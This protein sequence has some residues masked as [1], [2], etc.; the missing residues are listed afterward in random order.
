[1]AARKYTPEEAAARHREASRKRIAA[2]RK[3]HPEE[4]R[5]KKRIY[6]ANQ[7]PEKK[8]E[9][10]EKARLAMAAWR[11]AHPQ[12]SRARVKAYK[13]ANREKHRE[14]HRKSKAKWKAALDPDRREA[15]KGK[16]NESRR[17]SYRTNPE[18]HREAHRNYHEAHPGLATKWRREWAAA[19]RER[20]RENQKR[21]RQMNK[22]AYLV[23]VAGRRAR[24]KGL[25]FDGLAE[26]KA[27]RPAKCLCCGKELDYSCENRR[28]A[29]SLDRVDNLK[30][31]VA[32]NVRIICWECNWVKSDASLDRLK[33]IIA[34]IE[35][36]LSQ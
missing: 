13:L 10:K 33:Q 35:A 9:E 15:M 2:W 27:S 12:E 26:I 24:A 5:K 25:E 23:S 29:P 19:H 14:S 36:N 22:M 4:A 34:Y 1:M 30:G 3:E 31:Y 21:Q 28:C 17:E 16:R 32:A 11:K 6:R 20:D 7:T 8:A 18:K